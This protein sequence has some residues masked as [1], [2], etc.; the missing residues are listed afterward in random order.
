MRLTIVK[1]DGLVLKDGTGY[2]DLDLSAL[3]DTF[4]A[5]QWYDTY[6]DIEGKDEN[7]APTNT[8]ITDI[9]PYQWCID[10]WQEAHDAEQ[11]EIAAAEA[12]AAEALAAEAAESS[13][14]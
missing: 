3:P 13:P 9:T 11:A 8:D 12:A 1:E 14:E 4:K 6:G 2:G 5:L 7:N 10:K